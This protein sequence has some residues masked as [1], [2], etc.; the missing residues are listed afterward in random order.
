MKDYKKKNIVVVSGKA[1]SSEQQKKLYQNSVKNILQKP[2]SLKV[3][4]DEI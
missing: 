4:L 1:I 2:V 3:L